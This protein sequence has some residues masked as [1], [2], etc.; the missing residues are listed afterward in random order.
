MGEGHS[1]ADAAVV[2]AAGHIG[3]IEGLED[4]G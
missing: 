4:V 3:P 1:Q 2:L